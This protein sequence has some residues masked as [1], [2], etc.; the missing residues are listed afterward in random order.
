MSLAVI[1]CPGHQKKDSVE[2]WGN[3][4]VCPTVKQA[5]TESVKPLQTLSLPS[6]LTF[7]TEQD[8]LE[9][10][11]HMSEEENSDRQQYTKAE[12]WWVLP[13]RHPI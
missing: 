3:R 8:L 12:G 13:D 10:H 2:A 11:K 9:Q 4:L 1:H 7:Q 5:A 6:I